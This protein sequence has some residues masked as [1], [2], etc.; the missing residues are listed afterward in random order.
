[1]GAV[2]LPDELTQVIGRHVAEGR[3]ASETDFIIEAIQR[4][5][6]ALDFDEISVAADE[7]MADIDAGRFQ[8]I[9]GPLDMDRLQAELSAYLDQLA[10]PRGSARSE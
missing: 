1:M 3:A 5:A 10:E 7:G 9:S 4:Y 6:E 8:V 2:I